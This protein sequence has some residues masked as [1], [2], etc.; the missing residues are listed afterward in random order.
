MIIKISEPR[1]FEWYSNK[2]HNYFLLIVLKNL[3]CLR[4]NSWQIFAFPH[5]ITG[6][7]MQENIIINNANKNISIRMPWNTSLI[8]ISSQVH[9]ELVIVNAS[10]L[11]LTEI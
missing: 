11:Q 2:D 5:L 7:S 1:K 10:E 6:I 4:Y 3:K 8:F 9:F